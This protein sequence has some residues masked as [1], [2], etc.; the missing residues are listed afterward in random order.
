MPT[1]HASGSYTFQGSEGQTE[2]SLEIE[3]TEIQGELVD[4]DA[5]GR[6]RKEI[7]GEV[8]YEDG[9]PVLRILKKPSN[10]VGAEVQWLLEPAEGEDMTDS[11]EGRYTGYW[12]IAG[13]EEVL[14]VGEVYDPEIGLALGI[15]DNPEAEGEA[16][17][18]LRQT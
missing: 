1:Y 7:A 18:E 10:P 6:H 12:N 2:G 13:D 9:I 16:E 11:L 14:A 17:L 5:A 4:T 3:G 15:D 8:E